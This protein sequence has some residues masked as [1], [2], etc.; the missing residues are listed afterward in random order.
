MS[1]QVGSQVGQ[2]VMELDS[3]IIHAAQLPPQ[4]RSLPGRKKNLLSSVGIR[5]SLFPG[6]FRISPGGDWFQL[7]ETGFKWKV[8]L[9]FWLFLGLTQEWRKVKAAARCS[10]VLG[11]WHLREALKQWFQGDLSRW[12]LTPL[13]AGGPLQSLTPRKFS[14]EVSYHCEVKDVQ[15][16]FIHSLNCLQKCIYLLA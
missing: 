8:F 1:I 11:H 13:P 3:S 16:M 10:G 6:Y 7:E 9:I 14:P 15:H 12:V 4:Q 5:E 2:L